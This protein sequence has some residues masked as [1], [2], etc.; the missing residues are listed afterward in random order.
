MTKTKV[1][2]HESRAATPTPLVDSFGRV[3]NYLRI[4]LTERCNLRCT[5]CM[6]E[7]G[8][9]LTADQELLTDDEIVRIASAFVQRGVDK[10]RLTGGEPLLR[11]SILDLCERLR[12]LGIRDLAITT[13]GILLKR[14]LDPLV[15]GGVNLLNISLDTLVPA[16]F[17]LITRRRGFERVLE[18]IKRATSLPGL[19]QVKV[20]CVMKRGVNDDELLDFVELTRDLDVE[21]RFIE[22]MPFDQNKW[23]AKAIL[24]YYEMVDMIRERWPTF[25][26]TP[27]LDGANTVSK[28]WQVPDFVGRV[29][30]ISSMTDQFCGTCNRMRLTAD[31]SMKAC[32]FGSEEISLRDELRAGASDEALLGSIESI[33]GRKHA[34]LGGHDSPESISKGSNRPMV[35]IGG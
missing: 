22:F 25:A 10:I 24:P 7:K 27:R 33:L 15:E 19:D 28:T 31:G 35:K 20:N 4:S 2:M 8:V 30:F 6:P 12:G 5:Y 13:N 23:K 9:D 26:R 14:K 11:P 17:E 1:A 18:S 29:G 32:L 21:V 16:K 3:H 34:K